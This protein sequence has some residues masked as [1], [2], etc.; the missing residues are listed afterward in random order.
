[1]ELEVG[2]EGPWSTKCSGSRSWFAVPPFY[3]CINSIQGESA[4]RL[5]DVVGQ[6]AKSVAKGKSSKLDRSILVCSNLAFVFDPKAWMMV[7]SSRR[8]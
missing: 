3:G 8:S 1:M 2:S 6:A 4:K 7:Q 5:L